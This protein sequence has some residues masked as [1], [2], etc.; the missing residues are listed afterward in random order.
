VVERAAADAI[1][2]RLEWQGASTAAPGATLQVG[3]A[4][5]GGPQDAR[6]TVE[7][8][9][10][11]ALLA[12]DGGPVPGRATV[13]F[14]NGAAQLQLRVVGRQP[15]VVTPLQVGV[16]ALDAG[17]LKVEVPRPAPREI[18]IGGTP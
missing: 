13:P 5:A 3:L 16:V 4:L 1:S 10:D 7:I 18:A 6:G 11:Q 9:Y 14:A 15:G 2:A 8:V 12:V 17:G